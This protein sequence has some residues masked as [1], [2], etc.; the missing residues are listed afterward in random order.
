MGGIVHDTSGS[1]QTLFVE[2]PAAIEFGNRIR[3]LESDESEE[4]ERL[5]REAT[6]RLR[7]LQPEMVQSLEALVEL[8]S[9]Y[10]R[11]R[12]ARDFAC[13]DA[14]FA[15][16]GAGMR[17]H[18]ARHPLLV[19]QGIDVVPFDLELQPEQ[20]TLLLHAIFLA[21]GAAAFGLLGGITL[22]G[23]LVFLFYD[24]APCTVMLTLTILY[25]TA[26]VM[27][28]GRLNRVLRSWRNLPA[29]FEQLRK[30]R[31]CLET[32]FE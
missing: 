20:R 7:P 10:A 28:H 9:L 27:I 3:E 1:G 16:P 14:T 11:A 18:E 2:P 32:I 5:L 30:D 22:T 21:F 26:A 23:L 15:E 24:K 31:V 6:D 29:T 13:H 4:V 17:L 8:E 12:F 19:A 25:G